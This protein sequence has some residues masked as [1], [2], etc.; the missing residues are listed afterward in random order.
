MSSSKEEGEKK[1][2]IG[3]DVTLNSTAYKCHSVLTNMEKNL[4]K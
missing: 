1:I 2:K 4:V 3:E